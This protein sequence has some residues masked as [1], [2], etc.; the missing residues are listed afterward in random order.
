MNT[1]QVV[2]L[3]QSGRTADAESL[4]RAQLAVNVRDDGARHFLGL[5]L[6]QQRRFAEAVEIL[7]EL[8][9]PRWQSRMLLAQALRALGRMLEALDALRPALIERANDPQLQL[10]HAELLVDLGEAEAALRLCAPFTAGTAAATPFTRTAALALH[11]MKR[12]AEACV[13]FDAWLAAHPDDAI[14]RF[15]RGLSREALGEHA[16]AGDD[17]LACA[18]R[19]PMRASAWSHAAGCAA[20]IC[21]FERERA[22]VADLEAALQVNSTA[23]DRVEP[24]L[25]SFLPLSEP[26]RRAALARE[27]AAVRAQASRIALKRSRAPDGDGRIR[28]GWLSA[29]FGAH[30]VGG[31]ILPVLQ[32]LDRSR[33]DAVLY[34]LRDHADAAGDAFRALPS[35]FRAVHANSDAQIAQQIIDDGIDVLVDLAGYTDG[36]RPAVVAAHPAPV[37]LGWLGFIHTLGADFLDAQLLDAQVVPDSHAAQWSERR[38]N[39]PTSFLPGG[40]SRTGARP[41]RQN[42]GLPREGVLFACFNNAYKIDASAVQAW[43]QILAAVPGS[44]LVLAVPDAARRNLCGHWESLGGDA[45]ALVFVERIAPERQMDRAAACD[46]FL[47][48]FRYHAGA[49]AVSAIRAGLPVLCRAGASALAR[50][51]VS[52]NTQLGLQELIAA[53]SAGYVETAIRLG[54]D[55]VAR[56]DLRARLD[57]ARSVSGFDDPGRITRAL[58]QVFEQAV[59][60]NRPGI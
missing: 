56:A 19:Y 35:R 49:T 58:E 3:L 52:L 9:A 26:A 25:L 23:D 59:R 2:A 14:T 31:L 8:L 42:F 57:T 37:Q 11:Q 1:A 27:V 40:A 16:L 30:A 32:A 38:I 22:C 46:L 51:G 28:I 45:S 44:H 24:L 60:Q 55:P 54:Q 5:A 6:V 15:N 48:T 20:R 33:F 12:H 36:A 39:L 53:D 18:H 4:L 43:Q 17:F 13:A 47:D 21:D 7:G 10:L 34:S 29:D 41:A 50:M